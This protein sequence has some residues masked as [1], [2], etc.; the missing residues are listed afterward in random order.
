MTT[1]E[2]TVPA[3]L[4]VAALALALVAAGFSAWRFLPRNPG[5]AALAVFH[6]LTLGLLAWCL[7]MPGRKDAVTRLLKPR[8]LVVLDTSRS[9]ALD[10]PGAVPGRWTVA[11]DALAK[12]WTE[13]L[14]AECELEVCP[15]GDTLREALPVDDARSLTP[16]DRSTRL[17]EGLKQLAERYAGLNVAGALLLSDG[18]DTREASDAW[19]SDP[20]PFPVFTARLEPPGIWR[21][22]PALRIDSVT[23]ARRVT[24]GWKS[25][26]KAKISGQGTGGR[27]LTVQLFKNDALHHEKPTRL[28]DEGGERLLT[29]DLSHPEIGAFIYRVFIPPLPDEE[30]TE[31]NEHLVTVRVVDARNRLLYIEGTPRWEYKFLRR[32]LLANSRVSP[33]VF[34]TGPDGKPRGGGGDLSADLTPPELAQCKIVILG[35]LGA[36][37]LGA[38]RAANLVRFVEE[39]GSLVLLGGRKAWG[40]G[41]FLQ[42]PL[43]KVLPVRGAALDPLI[44]EDPFPV[45]LTDTARSHPA[46]AGDPEFWQTVPP[47]LSVFSGVELSPGARVLVNAQTP[48][49]SHPLVATQRYGAGKIAAILTDSL[50]RWQLGPEASVHKTYQRFW[51]QL[52]SWLLP[53]EEE[54]G[55]KAIELFA[56]REQ[57]FLGEELELNARLADQQS[58]ESV[59]CTIT[60]PDDREIPYR[61]NAGQVVTPS[62]K[63]FPGFTLP[64]TPESPGPYKAV[65]GAVVDGNPQSSEPLSFFVQPFSPETMPRP[66]DAR[67]LQS[68]AR[69]SGGRFFDSLDDMNH[70]LASLEF[71]AIEEESPEFRT[72]WRHWP[73]VALLMLSLTASWALRKLRNM[74]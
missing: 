43:G 38:A 18:V 68:I 2:H 64:F 12:P 3:G 72:L 59:A 58:A 17:R 24:V 31:D 63:S 34:Y 26:L 42:T 27:P 29:F 51:T 46:F 11:Q 37:E 19:A 25:E 57:V 4:I 41:G 66:A 50:W 23:T 20:R 55:D 44:A 48:A 74:P 1:C 65:A 21:K 56:D 67:V 5:N 28:P 35:D 52:I 60:L 33:I 54:L 7:L 45:R 32:A 22:T 36:A 69:A 30:V 73:L 40:A 8:F 16:N 13:S 53:K 9:M 14:A 39:G 62:G 70:A 61:M 6:A 10:P 15:L 71:H 47:V 49:G